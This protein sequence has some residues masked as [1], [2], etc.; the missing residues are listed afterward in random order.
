LLQA[1]VDARMEGRHTLN[2]NIFAG[3]DASAVRSH[4]V[5]KHPSSVVVRGGI[6][7]VVL[8]GSRGFHLAYVSCASNFDRPIQ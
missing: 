5:S 1:F 2:F 7:G 4:T 8:L 3:L 6:A